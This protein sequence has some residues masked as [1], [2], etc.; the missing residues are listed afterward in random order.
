MATRGSHSPLE[1]PQPGDMSMTHYKTEMKYLNAVADFITGHGYNVDA[2]TTKSRDLLDVWGMVGKKKCFL[3][4]Y[5]SGIY[6][7]KPSGNFMGGG[8]SG[9]WSV[10]DDEDDG[11][12][13][14]YMDHDG[15]FFAHDSSY[16]IG[17][18]S[19]IIKPIRE[20]A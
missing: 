19:H 11:C 6:A 15:R 4:I 20:T 9:V 8:I 17:A 16:L 13:E 1:E 14:V 5:V 12:I 3:E 10:G 7:P 18:L 2:P